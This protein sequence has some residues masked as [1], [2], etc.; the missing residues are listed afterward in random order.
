LSI[1]ELKLKDQDLDATDAAK[2]VALSILSRSRNRPHFGNAGEVEN[3]ISEAKSRC[4]S[5]RAALTLAER[6]IDV[7]FHPEDFDP[8]HARGESGSSNLAK[9]FEDVVGREDV[10]EKMQHLQEVVRA[11]RKNGIDPADQIPTNFV[12]SG[13]PG[14]L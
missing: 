13:P 4:M 2:K 14:K 8:D 6:P 7:V 11:Y 10:F 1:L 5:R 12:F 3:L 9:I